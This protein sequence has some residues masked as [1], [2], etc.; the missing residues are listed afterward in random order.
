MAREVFIDLQINYSDPRELRLRLQ[1]CALAAVTQENWHL[2]AILYRA[3]A[4]VDLTKAIAD[5]NGDAAWN[6]HTAGIHPI[7]QP[8]TAQDG[9]RGPTG[10]GNADLIALQLEAHRQKGRAE[11][12]ALFNQAMAAGCMCEWGSDRYDYMVRTTFDQACK[13]HLMTD[14]VAKLEG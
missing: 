14:P 3:I 6:A 11:S 13:V 10:D 9:V 12:A 7:V 4:E 2:A 5:S 1:A 8:R